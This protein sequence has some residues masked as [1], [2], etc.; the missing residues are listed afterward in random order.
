[1][2]NLILENFWTFSLLSTFFLHLCIR[3]LHYWRWV[4][5]GKILL[6]YYVSI[7][8]YRMISA[9]TARLHM[10]KTFR[11][12]T[13]TTLS[14]STALSHRVVDWPN[15]GLVLNINQRHAK[16]SGFMVYYLIAKPG[17]RT[18]KAPCCHLLIQWMWTS[19]SHGIWIFIACLLIERKDRWYWANIFVFLYMTVFVILRRSLSVC[20]P[21]RSREGCGLWFCHRGRQVRC[22]GRT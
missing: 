1:M 3:T 19:V 6:R 12:V 5:G 16:M 10:S 9:S 8:K 4:I 7:G 15:V 11:N 20:W 14:R 2:L 18:H 22:L 17:T 13:S 21:G